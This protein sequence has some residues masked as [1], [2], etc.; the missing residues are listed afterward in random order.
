MASGSR[1]ATDTSLQILTRVLG[2]AWG[3]ENKH[4]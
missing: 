2:G 4:F 3:V 1:K